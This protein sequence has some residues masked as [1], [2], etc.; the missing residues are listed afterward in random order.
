MSHPFEGLITRGDIAEVAEAEQIIFDSKRISV[1]ET[2][3]S[4]DVQAC[5]GSGKTTLIASKL[6][7]LAK[8]WK[9]QNQGVCMLSHTN[10]AKDEIID[11]LK[12][13]STIEAQRLLSYPH[14]I[15]TIQEFIGKF[16]AYPL[17]RSKGISINCFDTDICV[18]L[19]YS[20]LTKKTRTYVDKK[21]QY[22]N[23][24]YDF[25]LNYADGRI[26]V[27]VPTFPNG[28]SS[29]SY[30]D[31]LSVR[32]KLITDGYFFY[33]DAFSF[34]LMALKENVTLPSVLRQR[35][36]C[37]FLDEMQDTQ[38][39][40]DELLNE[41]FPP[42]V[43]S[44]IVQRFGDPDQA[45]FHGI[46]NEE[47]NE[48]FNK[49]SREDM[50]FVIH[51]SHRFDGLLAEK[52]KLFSFNEI[53]LKS[54]LEEKALTDGAEVYAT[55]ASFTHTIIVFNDD[56]RAH[57]VEFFA[58]IVSRQFT[59]QHKRSPNFSAKIL[60][61]VGNEIDYNADQL[62]IG[63]Y[64][65]YY[66]KTKAKSNFKEASLIEAVRYCRQSSSV[67]WSE[68]YK[69]LVDCVLRLMRMAG[70]LDENGRYFSV[71][72]LSDSLKANG[73]WEVFRTVIYLM[74][75]SDSA[76]DPYSWKKVCSWLV[77]VFDLNNLS[78]E[79]TEYMAYTGATAQLKAANEKLNAEVA[80]VS[81]PDN[82]IR[83]S[84]GFDIELST[85]HGV[86]GET[87]DAT[88]IVE[89]K[90]HIFDIETMLPYLI[91]ELPSAEHPNSC[92]P[93]KPNSRR[94]FK[95]NK[96]FMRQLYV[97]MSRPKHL[98]CLALHSD[99]ISDAQKELLRKKGWN[100]ESC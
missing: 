82:K 7:L 70:K 35:F 56:T 10:V 77:S 26:R 39:Y 6:I 28:S 21:S 78:T 53:P 88:L 89:T 31:L 84:D 49:K 16:V 97:A 1:L 14:F 85:I 76:I 50:D 37:T 65:R 44:L 20:K 96:V 18:D 55:G 62:K 25:D 3:H 71:T 38:K 41:I 23:V 64:W 81:L 15:G 57:V 92:L 42:V 17:I 2:M 32:N 40:Q 52:I 86:K 58:Q 54:E 43:S 61:A 4:I 60:G 34:A 59:A 67:D 75:N 45:I 63:H 36:P 90:N 91:G 51:K 5:P 83:H 9:F 27:N 87:H 19:I 98:L 79:T 74:L 11:R 72:T 80:I 47:P 24:L 13:S 22:S 99:H 66:D 8:K 73:H 29:P 69:C 68:G 33:R 94:A 48:S 93:D 46:G 30:S 12:R 95:P 100:I